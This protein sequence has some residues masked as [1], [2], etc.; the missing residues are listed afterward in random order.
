MDTFNYIFK[1][2][3]NAEKITSSMNKLNTTVEKIEQSTIELDTAFKKTFK[4]MEKAVSTIKLS[5]IIDQVDKVASGITSLNKPG[6]DLSTSMYDLSAMTGL[7][8]DKLQEIEGYARDSAK[9]FGGSAADGAESYKLILG[10]LSPEIA[11]VPK[12]LKG[13]GEAVAVTSKLMGGD[14]LAATEVLTTAM[15]QYQV[16]LDDPIKASAEM[17]KMMNVMAAAAGEGSAELPQIKQALEQAGMAAKG[18]NVSFEETNAAIQVLD[19]AGKKGSEGGVA[20]RN[21][22]STLGQGRFL[23]KNVQAELKAAG[24]D[25]N[26]LSDKTLP[27]SQRL[28]V[29]KPI[30]K[31]S[32]L[33]SALFGKEN[34]NAA[35]ALIGQTDEVDRLTAAVSNTKTAYEQAAIVM[36]SPAEKNA[37]LTATIDDFKIS[38]FNATGGLLGYADVIGGVATTIGELSPLVNILGNAY[39]FLTSKEQLTAFWE[40]ILTK[41]RKIGAF[42]TRLMT[43]EQW[44]LNAAMSANPVGLIVIGIAAVIAIIVI[45]IKHYDEFGAALLTVLGPLGQVVNGIMAI[46]RHWDSMK[47]AFQEGGFLGG[48]KRIGQVILDAVLYPLQQVLELLSFIPGMEFMAEKVKGLRK[49]M[50]LVTPDEDKKPEDPNNIGDPSA[51][52]ISKPGPAGAGIGAVEAKK[53]NEAIATGGTKNTT[54]NITLKDLIGVLNIKGND[55]KDSATQMQNQTQDSLMRVLAMANTSAE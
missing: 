14:Q 29:L 53:A 36:E 38:I 10:Q 25:I 3:S 17:A 32:A 24:V 48:L 37:R 31:D 2:T 45:A 6:M 22:M 40:G 18:A 49:S 12:A 46:Y 8:G 41:K 15:N 7:A 9:T 23:P 1:I 5:S 16:S 30:M 19:K 42:F 50:D 27:L 13:M 11:K 35:L 54:I 28:A 55:F 4:D 52:G 33:V 26:K 44:S 21:V 43:A 39:S 47:K 34:S 51:P 20:L